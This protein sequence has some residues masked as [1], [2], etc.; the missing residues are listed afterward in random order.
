MMKKEYVKRYS[1]AFKQKIVREYEAGASAYS[2]AQQYGIGGQTTIKRWVAQYGRSGFRAEQVVIQ[3]L[4][5]QHEVQAMRE[6]IT[7]LE[8]ALA[9][10]VLENRM[11]TT[12]LEVASQALDMDLKKTFGN[13]SSHRPQP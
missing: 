12:T 2:L 9:E 13:P 4:E 1:Q 10:S 6:R 7:A 11:L 5:D 3:S 8:R